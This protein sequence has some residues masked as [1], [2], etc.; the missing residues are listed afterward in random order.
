[1]TNTIDD[2]A[3]AQ[4]APPDPSVERHTLRPLIRKEVQDMIAEGII[5]STLDMA[6]LAGDIREETTFAIRTLL[7][8]HQ[9]ALGKLAT[10]VGQ[11][12]PLVAFSL[13]GI[14]AFLG[15]K[16]D[17]MGYKHKGERVS[18]KFDTLAKQ[19]RQQLL[20]ASPAQ[21]AAPAPDLQNKH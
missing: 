13:V 6:K 11:D 19:L 20:P 12:L 2:S 10:K 5:P 14:L 3:P 8:G 1:M 18:A 4:T 9:L 15:D 16:A 17:E 7:E 21:T